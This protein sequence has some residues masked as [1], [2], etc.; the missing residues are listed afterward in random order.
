[1]VYYL[2]GGLDGLFDEVY[3]VGRPEFSKGLEAVTSY[4]DHR[5][6]IVLIQSTMMLAVS[7]P[8][9]LSPNQGQLTRA[10]LFGPFSGCAQVVV[11]LV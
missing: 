10:P 6:C 2:F 4:L 5:M 8:M 3:K 7:H 9:K 11:L 1:M